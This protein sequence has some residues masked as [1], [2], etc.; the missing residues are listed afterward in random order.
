MN[1]HL[2][3]LKEKKKSSEKI[4]GIFFQEK[5]KLDFSRKDGFLALS[6]HTLTLMQSV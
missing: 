2:E 5:M 1:N 6:A 3:K 4:E